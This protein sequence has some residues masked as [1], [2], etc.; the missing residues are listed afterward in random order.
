MFTSTYKWSQTTDHWWSMVGNILLICLGREFIT[1]TVALA[2]AWLLSAGYLGNTVYLSITQRALYDVTIN[3]P[4]ALWSEQHEGSP[5]ILQGNSTW[6]YQKIPSSTSNVDQTTCKCNR[7]TAWELVIKT[8][9]SKYRVFAW[10]FT[11]S[12]AKE[13][14]LWTWLKES[15][16]LLVNM[17][18][19]NCPYIESYRRRCNDYFIVYMLRYRY[20][21]INY[22]IFKPYKPKPI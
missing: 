11:E 5:L 7:G 12:Q 18:I 6:T 20:V 14:S 19:H 10:C 9:L 17:K 1:C 8:V 4:W 2:A 16:L 21:L 3:C 13:R 15:Y 22:C